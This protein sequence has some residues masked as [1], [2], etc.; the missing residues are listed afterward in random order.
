MDLEKV[1]KRKDLV[2]EMSSDNVF[3]NIRMVRIG[4]NDFL[5]NAKDCALVLEYKKTD[6]AIRKHVPRELKLKLKMKN[7]RPLD[8]RGLKLNNAGEFFI[9]EDGL[10]RLISG[11]TMPKAEDFKNW[12][13]GEVLPT[14]RKTGSYTMDDFATSKFRKT[15]KN[16]PGYKE[17]AEFKERTKRAVS[18][19]ARYKHMLKPDVWGEFTRLFND[20]YGVNLNLKITNFMRK[21]ELTKRPSRREYLDAVNLQTKAHIIFE[22]MARDDMMISDPE[23]YALTKGLSEF[24]YNRMSELEKLQA[25]ALF[26]NLCKSGALKPLPDDKFVKNYEVDE[27]GKVIKVEFI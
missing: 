9:T 11:S 24:Y 16:L 7:F 3:G 8:S 26:E 20:I 14:F 19:L 18:A 2:M 23:N 5:F 25:Q 27:S 4:E 15:I 21:H 13:F 22:L 17:D 6:Q 1:Q 12:V 10:Y